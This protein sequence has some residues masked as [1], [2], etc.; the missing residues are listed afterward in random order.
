M[1]VRLGLRYHESMESVFFRNGVN[2]GVELIEW[3]VV[4][5]GTLQEDSQKV[6]ALVYVLSGALAVSQRTANKNEDVQLYLS[7]AGELV[8]GLA[9]LT[10]EPSFFTVRARH[11]A[12]VAMLSKNAFYS[13]VFYSPFAIALDH[14]CHVAL[15]LP[16]HL[17]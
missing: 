9:V 15:L 6:A 3:N 13:S 11:S 4:L 16:C 14:Q 8:G 12:C 1:F 10:G 7:H 5:N 2:D 17:S